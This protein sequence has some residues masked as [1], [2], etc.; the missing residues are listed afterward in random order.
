[1]TKKRIVYRIRLSFTN[2][3]PL[4][5]RVHFTQN[6]SDPV[7]QIRQISCLFASFSYIFIL[8]YLSFIHIIICS[9]LRYFLLSFSGISLYIL[10]PPFPPLLS[11][12][13]VTVSSLF[14]DSALTNSK[15]IQKLAFSMLFLFLFYSS[16]CKFNSYVN[17]VL[18]CIFVQKQPL[19]TGRVHKHPKQAIRPQIS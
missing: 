1:M 18:L 5:S 11:I 3:I 4:C 8:V 17:L 2:F 16:L 10:T 19:C 7:A 13:F 6:E 14:S 12:L 15:L 9:I